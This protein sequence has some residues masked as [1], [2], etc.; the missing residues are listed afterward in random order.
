MKQCRNGYQAALIKGEGGISDETHAPDFGPTQ[1]PPSYNS[2]GRIFCFT[3]KLN[4]R[5]LPGLGIPV[6]KGGLH[7]N[8]KIV[9][10]QFTH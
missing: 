1:T 6:P 2:V 9:N 3:K 8:R 10:M 5:C 7:T 4:P